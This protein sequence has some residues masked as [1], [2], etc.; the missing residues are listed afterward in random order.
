[1][2][3]TLAKKNTNTHI[4]ALEYVLAKAQRP[5]QWLVIAHNDARLVRSVSS[6]LKGQ[7]AA[8]LDTKVTT[9]SASSLGPI[10]GFFHIRLM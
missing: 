6:A 7:S 3:R 2:I 4:A 8:V 10:S 9:P 5:V 1:M